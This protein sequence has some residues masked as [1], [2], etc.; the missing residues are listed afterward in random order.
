MACDGVYIDSWNLGEW[1]RVH[2]PREGV[3]L[4]ETLGEKLRALCSD[5]IIRQPASQ[6]PCGGV[7]AA[8]NGS[9]SRHVNHE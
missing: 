3:V 6:K 9:F 2:E 5:F 8:A 7:I 1:L 4:S